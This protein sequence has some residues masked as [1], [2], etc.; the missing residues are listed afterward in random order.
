I[1]FLMAAL[2][3]VLLLWRQQCTQMRVREACYIA[4]RKEA[5]AKL[6]ASVGYLHE[7]LNAVP[8]PIFVKNHDHRFVIA[9][10]AY[11]EHHGVLLAQ[12]I[13]QRPHDFLPSE[14]A[15]SIE[16]VTTKLF[17]TKQS[18]DGES[19]VPVNNQERHVWTRLRVVQLSTGEEVIV[20]SVVDITE[21]KAL[22]KEVQNANT[23][24]SQIID[25]LPYALFVKDRN[26]Q[27]VLANEEACH[28]LN[29]TRE[30]AI[31]KR[32]V[33][34]VPKEFAVQLQAKD[35]ALF[36]NGGS[37][38]SEST[39]VTA[40]G[41][42]IPVLEQL[43]I[44]R[45]ADGQQMLIGS[46]VDISDRKALEERLRNASEYLTA[47]IA[48]MP[49]PL[50]IYDDAF[51]FI[52][53]NDAACQFL[54]HPAAD[55][56]GKTNYDILPKAVAERYELLL[57]EAFASGELREMEERFPTPDGGTRTLMTRSDVMVLPSGQKVLIGTVTDIT[58]LKETEDRL[59]EAK[60][61]AE[62]ANKAK[63]TF[64]SSM[65]HELRT[66]MNGVLGMTSLL[67]DTPLTEEQ[68]TLVDT[69]RA[70]GDALL[71]VINQILD[72][73]KIEADKLELEE[74]T[75][76]LQPMI[77]ET[78]DL[79]APQ[80]T[81]KGLML[82]Y[83]LEGNVPLRMNQDVGRLRQILTNLVSNAVKFTEQGEVTITVSAR[84]CD[85]RLTELRFKVHD[86]GMGIA[87][88]RIDTLFQ[89]FNQVDVSITRRYGGT[90]LGL[91]ISKRLA[92]AMGGTMWVESTVGQGTTFYFTIQAQEELTSRSTGT[93]PAIPEHAGGRASRFYGGIDLGRLSDKRILLLT[94]HETLR[95]LIE[96]HLQSWLLSLTTATTLP[97]PDHGEQTTTA[98][99]DF[100]AIIIDYAMDPDVKANVMAY[101][102]REATE[103]PLVVLTL[104]GERLSE[105][106]RFPR[107]ALVTKPLH[108]SQLHD[109]LVTVIYGKFVERLRTTTIP[110]HSSSLDA[111]YPLRI[112]LAEDNLVN[113]RVALGF[114]SKH[115]YRAD[116]AG[117][118]MEVLAAMERQTY[119][120]ILMDINMPEMDGLSTTETI[121]AHEGGPQPYIIAMTANAMYE[122]RKRCL[123][124]GMN[125]YI[126]KPIRIAELS[127][128]LQRAQMATHGSG[129][130]CSVNTAVAVD[131]AQCDHP[132]RV[133]PV[134]P[135]AL[136]EFAEMMGGDGEAMVTELIRLYLESTPQLMDEFEQGLRTQDM[137]SIQRAAHTLRSGSAQIGAQRFA[138]MAIEID[139]LCYQND[140]PT[141]R[142]KADAFLAEY[143]QVMDYFR[144]EYRQRTEEMAHVAL[145]R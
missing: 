43:K 66:P 143:T 35:E 64:L 121:R 125:D 68:L 47:V 26:H 83:F 84:P 108:A 55:I 141:I 93:L 34:L 132:H 67:L 115:G 54:G 21:Q 9:N 117:N 107:M 124:A 48:A 20:G 128:A 144:A 106:H 38:A 49:N 50:Y 126:S 5:E 16:R 123:D 39:F 96:Q 58:E 94:Q 73:S 145:F 61:A 81:E 1:M 4:E 44:C 110:I 100:D 60:E 42:I 78:L 52:Q 31:G 40:Q 18:A 118:G 65:T 127:A 114:L 63:S 140:L 75:F 2:L 27:F 11:A 22:Q 41:Q 37:R 95:R 116:V 131:R 51:R 32:M 28:L 24:L 111:N 109:A 122:D 86:T 19:V 129:K 136:C 98:L 87:P 45:L 15:D 102:L 133:Q 138:D 33:D 101:L 80:A 56:I 91:A 23:L 72:F 10:Q 71:T 105:A 76:D 139:D 142:T 30:A 7:V 79:V 6:R 112:L 135:D 89:S 74:V 14:A 134:D 70:S 25:A 119:D 92:E 130:A 53:V 46:R 29:V 13:N 8:V 88:D 77:E 3:I 59:R 90:G 99:A 113:Q 17:E 104:L 36:R 69:I 137:G 57:K 103:I 12:V 97:L 85:N 82:A 120:L 62:L